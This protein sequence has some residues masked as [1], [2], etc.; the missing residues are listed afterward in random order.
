MS[1]VLRLRN[2]ELKWEGA[3]A[4]AGSQSGTDGSG[5]QWG[6]RGFTGEADLWAG[7]G[8]QGPRMPTVG[9][10]ALC[11]EPGALSTGRPD[12]PPPTGC[13]MLWDGAP[14]TK[15]TRAASSRMRTRRSSNCSSTSSHRD[16]PGDRNTSEACP[17]GLP[18][19]RAGTASETVR[20]TP[21]TIQRESPRPGEAQV[22]DARGLAGP[23]S[24]QRGGHT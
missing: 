18:P 8:G 23:H 10:T 17:P 1:V 7:Q 19:F 22:G 6:L 21:P 11:S 24:A 3:A 5:V 12:S 13:L 20:P 16:F 9:R 2:P 15:E 14:L 4:D